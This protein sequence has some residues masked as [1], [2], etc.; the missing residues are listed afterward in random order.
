MCRSLDKTE[1][2]CG[3]QPLRVSYFPSQ[4]VPRT[5][6]GGRSPGGP[7]CEAILG[8]T[9]DSN[10]PPPFDKQSQDQ[11]NWEMMTF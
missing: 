5:S 7:K 11:N 2:N 10:N 1:G 8:H 4:C 6:L 3:E 9:G